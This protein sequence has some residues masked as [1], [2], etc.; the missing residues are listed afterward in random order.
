MTESVAADTPDNDRV[1]AE[2]IAAVFRMVDYGVIIAAAASIV[3]A[4]IMVSLDIT[5]RTR[6]TTFAVYISVCAGTHIG[7]RM[8]YDRGP[9]RSPRRTR[10]GVAF[11]AVALLEGLGWGWAPKGLVTN[12]SFDAEL[13]CLT[14]TLGIASGSI[15][16][17]AAYLPAFFA[18]FLPAT[19]P[20]VID[21]AIS[22]RPLQQKSSL[23]MVLYVAGVATYGV[24]ANRSFRRLVGLRLHAETLA[25]HLRKQIDVA[26]AA[27][28]AKSSF[29]ATASH[30]LRQPVHALGLFVGALRG[31]PMSSDAELILKHIETSTQA[32][33][34]L[35][36]ALLDISRL[37]AG[38]VEVERKA[39]SI[40]PMLERICGDQAAEADAKRIVVKV[41]RS[42]AVLHSDPILVERI[43][44]NLVSNAVRHTPSGRVLVGCRRHGA[45]VKVEVWDTGKGIPRDQRERV[46]QEYYQL[47]NEERDRT[48][49][50]GLG[51]AIVRR[52]TTLLGC[53][54]TLRSVVG[55][56]SC[57]AVTVRTAGRFALREEQAVAPEPP[58]QLGRMIV[59]VDDEA[60]IRVAMSTVLTHWGHNVLAAGSGA[61]AIE[62]LSDC[63]V[64]PDL[65][66]SDFRLRQHE[67]GI[68]VIEALRLEYNDRIPAI[69]ITGDTAPERLIEARE[70][71]LLLLHK[72][73]TN[74]RLRAAIANSIASEASEDDVR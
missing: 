13:L 58:L 14:T 50:L 59:V 71:G 60:D 30:D 67:T 4:A 63:P 7:L 33:D 52:L 61:E 55:R 27:N 43:L 39:F 57:F 49:G 66:I 26:E 37:D 17:F 21:F 19:V 35:F 47:G 23:L 74:S 42:T 36:T 10:W 44:R 20:S 54:L 18:F 3:L 1:R 12:G 45:N 29:L 6:G 46:F 65:I 51:L 16:A 28:R 64:R 62:K 31:M 2:A 69:L 38:V 24:L 56:G 53:E 41:V 22:Q 15:P 40:G 25:E 11:A 9:A 72:P 73:V 68:D 34:G 70:S 32:L 5:S 8:A 48:K